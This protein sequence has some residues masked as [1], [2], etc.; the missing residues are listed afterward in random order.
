MWADI[1][2]KSFIWNRTKTPAINRINLN[3][4]LFDRVNLWPVTY[5]S[6]FPISFAF[7]VSLRH[8]KYV[9]ITHKTW[10]KCVF[11]TSFPLRTIYFLCQFFFRISHYPSS[12]HYPIFLFFFFVT[13]DI[14]FYLLDVKWRRVNVKTNT[15]KDEWI[16]TQKS[17]RKTIANKVNCTR[18]RSAKWRHDC[19][20]SDYF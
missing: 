15:Y 1:K 13:S 11:F 3:V 18:Y 20:L 19:E 8:R 5:F 14:C 6:S 12:L 2:R 17:E 10:F 16:F 4:T 9:V 7:C